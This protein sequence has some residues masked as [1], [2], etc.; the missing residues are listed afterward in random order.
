M[1]TNKRPLGRKI[2][3]NSGGFI[4][5]VIEEV[6]LGLVED[7]VQVAVEDLLPHPQCIRERRPF[8]GRLEQAPKLFGDFVCDCVE[9]RRLCVVAP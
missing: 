3:A 5:A 4:R 8:V 9:E 6:L 2:R 1:A 7:Y